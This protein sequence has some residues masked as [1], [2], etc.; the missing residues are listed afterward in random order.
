MSTTTRWVR[1]CVYCL[2]RANERPLRYRNIY[3]TGVH[4]LRSM[5]A[6]TAAS[7]VSLYPSKLVGWDFDRCPKHL[8]PFV[9]LR[10]DGTQI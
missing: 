4:E 9:M 2:E 3:H 8:E 1:L 10:R 6:V 5:W 7:D